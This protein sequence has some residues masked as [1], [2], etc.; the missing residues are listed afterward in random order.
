MKGVAHAAGA[1]MGETYTIEFDRLRDFRLPLM[2]TR[3]SCKVLQLLL[4]AD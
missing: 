4:E 2:M 1:E 3:L